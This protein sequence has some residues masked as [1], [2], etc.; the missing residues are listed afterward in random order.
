MQ[1]LNERAHE[2]ANAIAADADD[3]GIAVL[4]LDC[5][6][7]VID[8]GTE[9]AG[10]SEAGRRLAE[11]CLAGLATV[12]IESPDASVPDIGCNYSV[13]VRTSNP[14]A[15]CMA[16]QYAG[17]ELKGNKFFAMGS[18][19]MR[20]AACRETIFQYIGNCEKPT[21]C[22]GVLETAKLPPNDVCESIA[23]KCGISTHNL[24]LL[25]ARTA[26]PAGTLQIVARSVETAL[27]KL[28]ELGF[29]LNRVVEGT[30]SAPLP[31]IGNTDLQ[32]IGW[33][34]DAILYGAVVRLKIRGEDL[35]CISQVPSSHSKDY[36][37][38]FEE[39][40]QRYNGDFY[41]IDPFLF[42][43]AVIEVESAETG[44]V[45]RYGQTAPEILAESFRAKK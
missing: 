14:L 31:P 7:R 6:T 15:A 19:P 10:N 1:T 25:V 12:T 5:G 35:S 13:H 33:T 11:V 41:S 8:C 45:V 21:R 16:S 3:L 28:Y 39:I 32:A 43:P 22:V 30:G 17:W 37:R 34:N 40:F 27:H 9:A 38:P 44:E 20:A 24:T 29:D 2:L 4:T 26:S 42:S 36:G 18:G 23:E